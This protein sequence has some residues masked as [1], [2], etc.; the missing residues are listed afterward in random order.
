MDGSREHGGQ[1][2]A[3]PDGCVLMRVDL[4]RALFRPR[5]ADRAIRRPLSLAS[6]CG[7]LKFFFLGSSYTSMVRNESSRIVNVL[8]KVLRAV[9]I[10][11]QKNNFSRSLFK[12]FNIP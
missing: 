8:F 4:P 10:I 5:H 3:G 6:H 2:R 1:V 12:F 11:F 7:R 9:W